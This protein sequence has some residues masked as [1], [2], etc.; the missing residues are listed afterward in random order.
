M[1]VIQ[2]DKQIDDAYLVKLLMHLVAN[3]VKEVEICADSNSQLSYREFEKV[4]GLSK[5][6]CANVLEYMRDKNYLT[7]Q[8]S[9][10]ILICP[11]CRKNESVSLIQCTKCYF[12]GIEKNMVAG[13]VSYVCKRCGEVFHEPK[14]KIHCTNCDIKLD[15]AEMALQ[16]VYCYAINHNTEQ[17]MMALLKPLQV[18]KELLAQKGYS[19][20]LFASAKG[21]SGITHSFDILASR[22]IGDRE[23]KVVVNMLV[24]RD[25]LV[26]SHILRS[27][28][29]ALDVAANENIIIAVPELTEES[30]KFANFYHI[31]TF[32]AK[33]IDNTAE[34]LAVWLYALTEDISWLK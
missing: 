18:I 32:E 33:D 13:K 3:N 7:R 4:L 24:D 9:R 6:S 31:R 14:L 21:E 25:A 30:R 8:C 20:S 12:N 16:D 26:S 19:T 23:V 27:Y 34:S 17:Q 29:Q 10:S 22:K 5:E 28:A 1:E 11:Q 15:I 2:T